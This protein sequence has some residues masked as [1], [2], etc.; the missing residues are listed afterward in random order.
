MQVPQNSAAVKAEKL[1]IWPSLI[2]E[3]IVAKKPHRGGAEDEGRHLDGDQG[4]HDTAERLV[5]GR[6]G[7]GVVVEVGAQ[8]NSNNACRHIKIYLELRVLQGQQW[9]ATQAELEA[10]WHE[11]RRQCSQEQNSL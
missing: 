9:H 3:H 4:D 10:I 6:H 7:E 5:D 2:G 1:R 8:R 11:I